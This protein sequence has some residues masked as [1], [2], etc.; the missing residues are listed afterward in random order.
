MRSFAFGI[1]KTSHLKGKAAL[2]FDDGPDAKYTPELL[3]LLKKYNVKATF[4][5]CCRRAC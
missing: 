3:D 5:F 4:F 1:F 2:T